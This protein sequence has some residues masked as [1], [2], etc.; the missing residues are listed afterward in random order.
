MSLNTTC[1]WTWVLDSSRYETVE[2]SS[3]AGLAGPPA[4]TSEGLGEWLLEHARVISPKGS[5]DPH[6]DLFAQ[7][8]DRYV[9]S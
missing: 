7:G 6:V 5:V 4:W 3:E 8:F 2:A 1:V 9:V